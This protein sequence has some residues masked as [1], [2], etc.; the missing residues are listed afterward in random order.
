M[1]PSKQRCVP[2]IIGGVGSQVLLTRATGPR[3][4]GCHVPAH[5]ANRTECCICV[6]MAWQDRNFHP[7]L[8]F[9]FEHPVCLQMGVAL[10]CI[11]SRG[12]FV[13][14]NFDFCEVG[15]APCCCF[16]SRTLWQASSFLSV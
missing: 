11:K 14:Q 15:P 13:F 1:E 4:P 9:G 2:C 5:C 12:P 16:I 6:D 10:V 8:H 3:V 7:L